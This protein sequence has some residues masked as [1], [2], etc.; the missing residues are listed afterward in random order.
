MTRTSRDKHKQASA[1]SV[2]LSPLSSS[3]SALMLPNSNTNHHLRPRQIFY[4]SH[5]RVVN[6]PPDVGDAPI[7][8]R[9]TRNRLANLSPANAAS[10][11]QASMDAIL[12]AT[13]VNERQSITNYFNSHASASS[14][15]SS[16]AASADN[17]PAHDAV[18]PSKRDGHDAQHAIEAYSPWVWSS[19]A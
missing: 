15:S 16:S 18:T 4:V 10:W 7:V 9:M 17:V 5:A 19:P 2:G 3:L 11:K 8:E 12:E 1:Q 6:H 13:E 14:A